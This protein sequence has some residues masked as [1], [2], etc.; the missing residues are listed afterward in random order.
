[1]RHRNGKFYFGLVL[2]ALLAPAGACED[3]PIINPP[4]D[5][6]VNPDS[7][8][9]APTFGDIYSSATFGMC[10]DCHT[11]TAPGFVQGTETTQDWTSS[12]TAFSSLQG[13]AAGLEGNFAG[14]NDVPLVGATAA[15][16]L[17][18]AVLD[19]DVRAAFSVP[20]FP[21][22]TADAIP[23]ETLR[24]GSVPPA[25]LQALKDFIDEGGFN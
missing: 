5:G 8:T 10:S 21:S 4:T 24:V 25:T 7:G 6:G 3:E 22:C 1:M 12:A 16:S 14:C 20:G 11:P 13:N 15:T 23:D 17:I 18:V 9:T 2:A 19:P